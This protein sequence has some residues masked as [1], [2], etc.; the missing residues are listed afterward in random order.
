MPTFHGSRHVRHVAADMFDLVADF[1]RY[2]D[3][4]PFCLSARTR[5][6]ATGPRGTVTLIAEMEVGLG[7]ISQRFA[8]RDTLDRARLTIRVVDI[9]GP[10]RRFEIGLVV[11]RGRRRPGFAC[12]ILD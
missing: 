1:E 8:T 6:R 10:F 2:P 4:V 12:R 7:S 5:R 3:F 11:S 9:D